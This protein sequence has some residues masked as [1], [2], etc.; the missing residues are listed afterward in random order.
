MTGEFVRYS[1]CQVLLQTEGITN[2]EDHEGDVEGFRQPG[3]DGE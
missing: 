1:N 3:Q 2:F